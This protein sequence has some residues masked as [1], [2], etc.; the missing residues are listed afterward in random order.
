MLHGPY[1]MLLL[2]AFAA[3]RPQHLDCRRLGHAQAPERLRAHVADELR[4][5][6]SEPGE[7]G[8]GAHWNACTIVTIVSGGKHLGA[9]HQ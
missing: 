6:Q 2:R 9:L 7:G 4:G 8:E 1:S 3:Q 5:E